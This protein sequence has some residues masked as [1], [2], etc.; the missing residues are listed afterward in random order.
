MPADPLAPLL[1]LPG[2][3]EAVTETRESVDALLTHRIL[4]R[5]SSEVSA[6]SALRGAWASAVLSGADVSLD[7][8]R[9]GEVADP[10]VQGA[11]RV[12]AELGAVADT[13]TKAPRQV[14]ARLHVLAA[15]DLVEDS[16]SLGRPSP[17]PLIAR[18]IDTLAA[19]L[20]A[21]RAPAVVVG[22]VVLGE[23]LTLDAFA[24]STVVV[25]DAALR[26]CLVE[27]GL[28]PKSLV[29]VEVGALELRERT[30]AALAG[31]GGGTPAGLALWIRYVAE[32]VLLGAREA[33]AICEA[34]QRG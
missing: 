24:P 30:A 14:L 5:R 1:E 3:A 2:V 18:R 11:L 17:D 29:V 6:E 32:T 33:I 28:D 22:A 8:L 21:T 10:V 20:S 23:L 7:A 27:R 25:A 19:T 4:R 13:W 16:G 31:F 9:G 26:L 34:L 15:A 12:S